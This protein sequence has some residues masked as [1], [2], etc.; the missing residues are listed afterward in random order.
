LNAQDAAFE[1]YYRCVGAA[2]LEPTAPTCCWNC[3][4]SNIR[5]RDLIARYWWGRV[6]KRPYIATRRG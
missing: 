5:K 1:R 4:C 2:E 6:E 3:N